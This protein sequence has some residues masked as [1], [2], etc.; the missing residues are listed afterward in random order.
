MTSVEN[1]KNIEVINYLEYENS[2]GFFFSIGTIVERK[3]I[4]FVTLVAP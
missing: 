1:N 2:F 4:D 3:K